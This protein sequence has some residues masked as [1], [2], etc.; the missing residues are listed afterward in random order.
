MTREEAIEKYTEKFGSFPYFLTMGMSKADLI[1]L[2]K[3]SLSSGEEIEPDPD[4]IY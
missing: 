4:L 1:A 2:I 3:D